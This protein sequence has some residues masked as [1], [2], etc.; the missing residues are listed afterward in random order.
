M[1]H[2]SYAVH[3]EYVPVLADALRTAFIDLYHGRNILEGL[4]QQWKE[5]GAE[6]PEVPALGTFDVRDVRH[7]QFFFS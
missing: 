2:D 6:I 5:T 1:I 7:A 4:S 3:A